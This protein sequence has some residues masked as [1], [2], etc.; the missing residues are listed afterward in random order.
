M[1]E[2]DV[3]TLF[4]N[5]QPSRRSY[6]RLQGLGPTLLALACLTLYGSRL[7]ANPLQGPDPVRRL[8]IEKGLLSDNN[9]PNLTPLA[10]PR[11]SEQQQG[12][13][14]DMVITSMNFLDVPYQWG[15]TQEPTGFDCSGFTK[16]IFERSMG[17]ILPRRAEEQ[18]RAPG[19]TPIL[20][21]DLKAGDLV[22][23]NTLGRMFSHVGIYVGEGKFIHSPRTGAVVR[24]ED[25][26]LSYW[27]KRF[28]G[29]RRAMSNPQLTRIA[30]PGLRLS[31]RPLQP[32][33]D[34][35]YG[36]R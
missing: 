25:M 4:R 34:D 17:I 23:F 18:A 33:T 26:R 32:L 22:F 5:L 9:L 19:L 16:H 35:I 6:R 11:L 8:L 12:G 21:D 7:W 3:F 14:A 30:R 24:V 2:I 10:S 1:D 13:A 36:G 20:R 15:G 28:N 27:S 31:A 29:A